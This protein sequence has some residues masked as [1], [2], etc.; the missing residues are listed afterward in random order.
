MPHFSGQQWDNQSEERVVKKGLRASRHRTIPTRNYYRTIL[1]PDI[2]VLKVTENL[3]TAEC[4]FSRWVFLN[5]RQTCTKLYPYLWGDNKWVVQR[6]GVHINYQLMVAGIG[7][8]IG[9][10]VIVTIINPLPATIQNH[11]ANGLLQWLSSNGMPIKSHHHLFSKIKFSWNTAMAMCLHTV[12][13]CICTIFFKKSM[14]NPKIKSGPFKLDV[15]PLLKILQWLSSLLRR[16]KESK[17]RVPPT[18]MT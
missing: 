9:I 13:G 2:T 15:F 8:D 3:C 17:T 4:A 6:W 11:L 5:H 10:S 18:S 14:V 1:V 16:S 12:H 7:C